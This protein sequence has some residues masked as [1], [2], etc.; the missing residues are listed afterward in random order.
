MKLTEKEQRIKYLLQAES[1]EVDSSAIWGNIS[2]T[3]NAEPTKKR[4]GIFVWLFSASLIAA[5]L[6]VGLQ[7]FTP[8]E[9]PAGLTDQK[10]KVSTEK[11]AQEIENT[12]L[13][14]NEIET[15]TKHNQLINKHE[16][17]NETSIISNIT[18]ENRDSQ[19][20][21]SSSTQVE[22]VQ[23]TNR[24][25]TLSQLTKVKTS[26]GQPRSQSVTTKTPNKVKVN[27][28]IPT[29]VFKQK[30]NWLSSLPL[31][32]NI[33]SSLRIDNA[34]ELQDTMIDI[35]TAESNS[36]WSIGMGV[37]PMLYTSQNTL[38][39]G[40]QLN[41][42]NEQS[43]LGWRSQL[44]LTRAIS[45][46]WSIQGGLSY[47]HG[48]MRYRDNSSRVVPVIDEGI[49]TIEIDN[50]GNATE[51]IGLIQ[52][53]IQRDNDIQWHQRHEYLDATIALQYHHPI[54]MGWYL[55]GN[56]GAVANLYESHQG[57]YYKIEDGNVP[58]LNIQAT[59]T[60]IAF[61]DNSR[62]GLLGG[63]GVQKSLKNM[64]IGLQTN[65]IIRPNNIILPG[66]GYNS[67]ITQTGI[68]FTINYQPEWD[69]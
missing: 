37:G 30:R 58:V 40:D 41:L 65:A 31:I 38:L 19:D 61:S 11:A 21:S 49:S 62:L 2:D 10:T 28:T 14:I 32:G 25:S 46:R 35:T 43:V 8:S 12:E 59:N 45:P 44:S 57:Y 13:V 5:M 4:R 60:S 6:I 26:T 55:T 69:L 24:A 15:A 39:S 9:T 48:A 52:K 36:R 50:A 53:I 22:I 16:E 64:T 34:P 23:S 29:S 3:I 33:I 18:V 7:P 56:V 54:R 42:P 63:V 68:Q 51:H 17:K 67:K 47:S 20:L 66:N 1:Q 27:T